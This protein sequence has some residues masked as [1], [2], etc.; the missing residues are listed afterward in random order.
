M[1]GTLFTPESDRT[2]D[3]RVSAVWAE[4]RRR[5]QQHGRSLDLVHARISLDYARRLMAVLG[6]DADI[7]MPAVLLH[8]I[9]NT[10]L[11]ADDLA[12][13]TI[14]P[15]TRSA[16]KT[17][18][19]DLK[20]Q[21]LDAGRQLSRD[22]LHRIGCDG[23]IAA[24]VAEIVGDHENPRGG[25]PD[26]R[27]DINKVVVS[28]ADKL[29]RYSSSGCRHMCRLHDISDEEMLRLNIRQIPEW[30][31]TDAAKRIA[32]EELRKMPGAEALSELMEF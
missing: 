3:R 32:M 10:A 31:I 9:G 20:Q 29:Y 28:D 24:A 14:N 7:V 26:D 18:S 16:A 5:F 11:D 21:H 22:I 19:T 2:E 30:L 8:D 17:Y 23:A 1:T 12:R 15:G 4:C 13:R 6:G 25:P 27:S